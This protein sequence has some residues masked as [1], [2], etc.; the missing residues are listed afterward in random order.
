M[1]IDQVLWECFRNFASLDEANAAMHCSPVRYSPITFR[2]AEQLD[3][4]PHDWL[5]PHNAK[6]LDRVLRDRGRY[7]EDVGRVEADPPG[8]RDRE[9]T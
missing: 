4:L 6:W 8:S 5:A 3:P 7:P 9:E 2:V 1:T